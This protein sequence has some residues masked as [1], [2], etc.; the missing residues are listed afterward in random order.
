MVQLDGTPYWEDS[1]SMSRYPA[2][3]R[4]L[5]GRRR[6]DRRRDYRPDRGVP[7][8]ARGPFGRRHRSRGAAEAWTRDTRPRTSPASPT[9]TSR[10][11][12]RTSDAIT[13]GR[14][15]T[16]V[17]P[18]CVEIDTIV[19]AEGIDCG[20]TWVPGY[21]FA[22]L[23]ADP[24]KARPRLQEEARAGGRTGIRSGVP[25]RGAVRRAAGRRVRGSGEV[26]SAQVSGGAREAAS[27]AAGRTSS[28]IPNPRKSSTTPLSVKAGGHTISCDHVVIATHTPLMGKTN[29]ASATLLQTKLYLYTSY[30]LGGRVP[31]GVDARRV[32][33]GH[34]VAV[35]LP[36]PRSASRLRLRDLRRRGSQ[37]RPGGRYRSVLPRSRAHAAAAS[38]R[39][40]TSRTAGPAR[41]SRRTTACRS[42]ARPRRRQFAATGYAGNGMTFG[43]LA[44]IMA[45][46]AVLGR[47]NPWAEL[48]D[49]GRTKVKGRRL[50][51]PEGE[52]RLSVS[53]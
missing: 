5:D 39:R 52:H 6:G 31:K 50:G 42:S 18:P 37:D 32:V 53:T 9:P 7:A 12:S 3:D 10:T 21:K 25:R 26:P 40:S 1:S 17:W 44:G 28:S 33:L 20:W 2:L 38:F 27:T 41:S 46:D 15:G 51:L 14:C 47:R 19:T 36:A 24:A 43:T 34:G 16:R 4:D 29:I 45:R 22:A 8:E 23:D 48:F 35:S 13:R 49:A 30:V 11:S